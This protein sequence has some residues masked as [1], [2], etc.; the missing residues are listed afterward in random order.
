MKKHARP[1]QYAGTY[2]LHLY[3]D[4]ND[5]DRHG[6]AVYMHEFVG[7]TFTD[8]AKQARRVG[9]KIDRETRT[10]TC[11]RCAGQSASK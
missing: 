9:W 10:A 3:C 8:C 6:G 7:D 2:L 1:L 5:D 4:V 11:P